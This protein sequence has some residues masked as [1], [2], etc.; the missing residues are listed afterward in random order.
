MLLLILVLKAAFYTQGCLIS[1]DIVGGL[2]TNIS[3]PIVSLQ[4]RKGSSFCGGSIIG[5][6]VVLTAKHCVVYGPPARVVFGTNDLDQEKNAAVLASNIKTIIFPTKGDIALIV[7]KQ[8][9]FSPP[10]MRLARH[11]P[12]SRTMMDVIGWGFT[13]EGSGQT[14]KLLMKATVPLVSKRECSVYY[15]RQIT[16]DYTCAGFCNGK[17]DSCQGDSGGPLFSNG[18][19]V[20][21]VSFG[22]GCA[23]PYAFGVYAKIS[24]FRDFFIKHNITSFARIETC[25]KSMS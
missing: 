8:N 19:Q 23:R 20:G 2:P 6:N 5:P 13:R 10:F 22:R 1:P 16:N 9:V 21:V 11:T 4:Q 3:Y 25:T 14:T 24:Y 7:F 17:I 18:I 12:R 15:P